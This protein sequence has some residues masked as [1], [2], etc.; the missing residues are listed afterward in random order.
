M[1][2]TH[3]VL[4]KIDPDPS[5]IRL[6]EI[7]V[8]TFFSLSPVYKRTDAGLLCMVVDEPAEEGGVVPC[9]GWYPQGPTPTGFEGDIAV[10]PVEVTINVEWCE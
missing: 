4:G 7:G 3:V 9:V 10:Y 5:G 6:D 2:T 1:M 8:G